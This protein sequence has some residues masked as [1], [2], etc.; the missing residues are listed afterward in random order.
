MA[1]D[2]MYKNVGTRCAHTLKLTK[3]VCDVRTF[4]FGRD[5]LALSLKRKHVTAHFRNNITSRCPLSLW[6]FVI[7]FFYFFFLFLSSYIVPFLLVASFV[8]VFSIWNCFKLKP[9]EWRTIVQ[10]TPNA[11]NIDRRRWEKHM[12]ALSIC[13]SGFLMIVCDVHVCVVHL[14]EPE[15]VPVI[16]F[17]KLIFKLLIMRRVGKVHVSIVFVMFMEIKWSTAAAAAAAAI[18]KKCTIYINIFKMN[19][20]SASLWL[21]IHIYIH[22]FSSFLFLLLPLLPLPPYSCA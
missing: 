5:S 22:T 10:C 8:L 3:H 16:Y 17:C 6:S 11:R 1:G 18:P 13:I 15:H 2:V 20:S 21:T 19:S 9:M 4:S 14:C 7:I 12:P